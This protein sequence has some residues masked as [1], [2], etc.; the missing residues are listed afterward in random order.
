MEDRQKVNQLYQTATGASRLFPAN[1]P[2]RNHF[3]ACGG[4]EP[5]QAR[6]PVFCSTRE[7]SLTTLSSQLFQGNQTARVGVL[8][9]NRIGGSAMKRVRN[10]VIGAVSVF[11]LS[12]L[13]LHLELGSLG[14]YDLS[15]AQAAKGG[16]GGGGG[17]G[18][19]GGNGK[20]GGGGTGIAAETARAAV[21]E[22]AT[23]AKLAAAVTR[24]KPEAN[25][26]RQPITPDRSS[27]GNGRAR[28]R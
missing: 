27:V 4:R 12:A 21:A 23:A 13:P 28:A 16:N 9:W 25:P 20:G 2:F 8:T 7:N 14:S 17:N 24:A 5:S 19:S 6:E 22:T 11:A 15:S 26:L 3:R 10:I 18:H 1:V